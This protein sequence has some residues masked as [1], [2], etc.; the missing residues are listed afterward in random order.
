TGPTWHL[1]RWS[2]LVISSVLSLLFVFVT[3]C[4]IQFGDSREIK[5]WINAAEAL[6]NPKSKSSL[7]SL[8][9]AVTGIKQ[10]GNNKKEKVGL[11]AAY[12]LGLIMAGDVQDGAI[13]CKYISRKYKGQ[14]FADMVSEKKIMRKCRECQ[15]HRPE[16]CR[17]C[18]AEK[19]CLSCAGAGFK[20][21]GVLSGSSGGLGNGFRRV[22]GRARNAGGGNAA[23]AGADEAEQKC[24][25]CDGTGKCPNC[26]GIGREPFFCTNCK[27]T[28]QE[29]AMNK[30]NAQQTAVAEQLGKIL[31]KRNNFGKLNL[32]MQA[33]KFNIGSVSSSATDGIDAAQAAILFS[34]TEKTSAEEEE[35]LEFQKSYIYDDTSLS[36]ADA[37]IA[38][39]LLRSSRMAID[40]E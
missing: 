13:V 39:S 19:D 15:N 16:N 32:A 9:D 35:Y 10:T 31:K 7:K 38:L 30:I 2:K 14:T 27:G 4:F 22:I 20:R 24:V 5:L 26:K 1:P 3:M 12:G 33:L 23:E 25:S 8:K 6:E 36:V 34:K 18:S 40:P 11:I 17:V 28:E 21:R 29:I 37:L